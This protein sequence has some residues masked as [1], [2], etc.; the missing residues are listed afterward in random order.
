MKSLKSVIQTVNIILFILFNHLVFFSQ[1]ISKEITLNYQI[2]GFNIDRY[3]YI[4][5]MSY[6]N[7]FKKNKNDEILYSYSNKNLGKI[8]EIDVSNPLRPL[9]LYK[10][11]GVICVLDNTLSQQEKNIDLNSLSLYQTNSIANSNFD[12]GI[13]LFDV[14]MN[15]IIKI[16]VHSNIT[17]RSGNLAVILPKFE[18]PIIKMQEYNKH[19]FAFTKN[20]IFEFD[21]FGSLLHTI[22][23]SA[24]MGFI[25]DD[26]NYILYDGAHF[27]K[28]F[29]LDFKIDTLME[30]NSYIKVVGEFNEIVG[31]HK[32]L[33]KIQFL[34]FDF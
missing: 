9:L 10:D 24:S 33:T 2:D 32:D 30:N 1:K 14:D 28:Y 15:E 6:D 21:Q 27:L 26:D 19:L 29:K 12:N 23:A 13:W 7:L 16:D 34:E 20:Q 5:E 22:P 8:S 17:Y 4:Y 31:L 3:G 18:G 25:Y 11:M